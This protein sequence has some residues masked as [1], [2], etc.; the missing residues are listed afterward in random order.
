MEMNEQL[1]IKDSEGHTMKVLIANITPRQIQHC[2][3][4][5]AILHAT[6]LRTFIPGLKATK[7]QLFKKQ[8]YGLKH[9][10]ERWLRHQNGGEHKDG[11]NYIS[12]H[13]FALA[14]LLSGAK[15]KKI[16]GACSCTFDW[17]KEAAK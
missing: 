12:E 1:F 7:T 6:K 8:A 16:D 14:A 11:D 9:D 2:L 4:F 15:I 17:P 5:I 13:S 3:D 10:V